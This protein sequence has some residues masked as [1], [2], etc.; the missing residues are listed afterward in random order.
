MAKHNGKGIK[1]SSY[2][3]SQYE[4]VEMLNNPKGKKAEL[5]WH[6]KERSKEKETVQ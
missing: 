3:P 2:R 1:Y 4:K 6:E 5:L